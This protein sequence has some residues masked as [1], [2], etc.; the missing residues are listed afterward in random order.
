MS[1]RPVAANYRLPRSTDGAPSSGQGTT[2]GSF[3]QPWRPGDPLSFT[4]PDTPNMPP[5]SRYSA[6]DFMPADKR[7]KEQSNKQ[8]TDQNSREI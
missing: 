5:P 4:S 3:A 8:N 7:N 6:W 1:S 2:P